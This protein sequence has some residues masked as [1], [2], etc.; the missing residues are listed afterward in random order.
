MRGINTC[1]PETVP[2]VNVYQNVVEM[3]GKL[4]VVL[5]AENPKYPN[6]RLR[7][8]TEMTIWGVATYCLHDLAR[9]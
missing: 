6:I 5:K 8:L 7:E 9:A 2:T 4:Y 1:C 3:D